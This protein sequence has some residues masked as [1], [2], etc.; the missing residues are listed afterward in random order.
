MTSEERQAIT[1]EVIEGILRGEYIEHQRDYIQIFQD[2]LN[3]IYFNLSKHGKY[4]A[5]VDH[6]KRVIHVRKDTVY[7]SQFYVFAA[8][9]R[10]KVLQ[11]REI[12]APGDLGEATVDMFFGDRQVATQSPI[13]TYQNEYQFFTGTPVSYLATRP[14]RSAPEGWNEWRL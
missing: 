5:R 7:K 4:I 12:I 1:S 8:E 2:E 13:V 9:Q 11:V 3:A 14:P 10:Y 6:Y